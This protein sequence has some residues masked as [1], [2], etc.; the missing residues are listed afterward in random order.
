MSRL[1]KLMKHRQLLRRQDFKVLMARV[2]KH[3]RNP[4]PLTED[5]NADKITPKRGARQA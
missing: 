4:R 3:V 1:S 2:A 5:K